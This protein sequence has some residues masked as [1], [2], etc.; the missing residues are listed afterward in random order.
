MNLTI[1]CGAALTALAV[2]AAAEIKSESLK[3]TV[4]KK[5]SINYA[6]TLPDGYDAKDTKLYPLILFLHGAGERGSDLSLVTRLYPISHAQN[7]QGFPFILVAPQ[8]PDGEQW[9]SDELIA[10]LDKVQKQYKVDP[11]RIYLTGYSLGGTGTWQLAS[12]HPERFAAIAPVCGRCMPTVAGRMKDLPIWVFHGDQD[13][14]VSFENSKLMV[15]TLK[16]MQAKEVKFTIYP[17]AGH[18][19][20][21]RT[22]IQPELYEWFLSHKKS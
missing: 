12:D 2:H 14:V 17:G 1:L 3:Q 8:C 18:D 11:D 16:G 10:L 15:D 19:I 13:P 9:H 7:T 20:C 21:D 5:I 6:L 4:S 22:Y